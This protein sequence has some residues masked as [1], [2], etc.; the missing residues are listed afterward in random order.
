MDTT[1][2]A[3]GLPDNPTSWLDGN[4]TGLVELHKSCDNPEL[5]GWR[6]GGT[7]Y[8]CLGAMTNEERFVVVICSRGGPDDTPNCNGM[9]QIYDETGLIVPTDPMTLPDCPQQQD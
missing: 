8:I 7:L 9:V 4:V 6:L 1:N 2:K 5:S 3:S